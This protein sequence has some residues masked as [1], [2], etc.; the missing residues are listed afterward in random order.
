MP[1][2]ANTRC[3]YSVVTAVSLFAVL[4]PTPSVRAVIQGGVV[5]NGTPASCTEAAFVAVI[6]GRRRGNVQLWSSAGNDHHHGRA[7]HRHE[8]GH[9]WWWTRHA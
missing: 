1:R 5:G 7:D 9:R 6:V 3:V 8:H 2:L 4:T